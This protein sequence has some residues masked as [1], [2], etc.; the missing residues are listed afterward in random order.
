MKSRGDH[1]E[2]VE[3]RE[4]ARSCSDDFQ[5]VLVQRLK[6]AMTYYP[7]LFLADRLITIVQLVT[8]LQSPRSFCPP[9]LRYS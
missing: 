8:T 6:D 5:D 1:P 4:L 2:A 7:Q 3:F 9:Y